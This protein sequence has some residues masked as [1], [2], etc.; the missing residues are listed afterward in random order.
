M[1]VRVSTGAQ[2][3][4]RG[5]L[6]WR[7]WSGRASSVNT[8]AQGARHPVE[9]SVLGARPG[10]VF[11]PPGISACFD[12]ASF[13]LISCWALRRDLLRGFRS[14][15]KTQN[16]S[17][18]RGRRRS[19]AARS[20]VRV[21]SPPSA[22]ARG[23]S[24]LMCVGFSPRSFF[25]SSFSAPV[26]VRIVPAS[27]G[28]AGNVTSI[29]FGTRRIMTCLSVRRIDF[30]S[31]LEFEDLSKGLLNFFFMSF[32]GCYVRLSLVVGSRSIELRTFRHSPL[33]VGLEGFRRDVR[34]S[35]GIVAL[36]RCYGR[37][38]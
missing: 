13:F 25:G 30:F 19:A 5:S 16:G 23:W 34:D 17:M 9:G 37:V 27:C 29:S 36:I 8:S 18:G 1:D 14:Y 21:V 12:R 15:S 11:R 2:L 28:N 24:F 20:L 32:A 26:I 6:T 31:L 3:P 38:S 33:L 10:G 35:T 4:P 22:E 7:A